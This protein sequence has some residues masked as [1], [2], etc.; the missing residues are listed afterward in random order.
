MSIVD[1]M[2]EYEEQKEGAAISIALQAGVLNRCEF[3]QE[4]LFKGESEILDAYKLGSAMFA[5]GAFKDLFDSQRDVTDMI[6]K[7]VAENNLDDECSECA[8]RRDKD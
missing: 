1:R 8:W 5:R 3:H 7:V 4:C 2:V 6:D